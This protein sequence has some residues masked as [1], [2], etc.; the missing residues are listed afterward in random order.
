[1]RACTK[2]KKHLYTL[3]IVP[4]YAL[5]PYATRPHFF[6]LVVRRSLRGLQR[7]D[8][9]VFAEL[10][11]LVHNPQPSWSVA[12]SSRRIKSEAFA[13]QPIIFKSGVSYP[14]SSLWFFMLSWIGLLSCTATSHE[15]FGFGDLHIPVA[16]KV[17]ILQEQMAK[18]MAH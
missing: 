11:E 6:A 10:R 4:K 17:A 3:I 2:F 7:C 12:L 1:M 13:S 9:T 14:H 5:H 18:T 15:I 16:K 8:S